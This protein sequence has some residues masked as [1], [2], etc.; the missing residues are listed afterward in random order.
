M[1]EQETVEIATGE[2]EPG[3]CYLL[4]S[5]SSSRCASKELPRVI[6]NHWRVE[7]SPHHRKDRSWGE[8]ARTLRRPGLEG[9]YPRLSGQTP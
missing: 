1:S 8:D 3:R 7:N 4:T 5:L 6:R 9:V 2:G